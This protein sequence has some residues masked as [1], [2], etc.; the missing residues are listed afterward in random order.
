MFL[1]DIMNESQDQDADIYNEYNGDNEDEYNDDKD[2]APKPKKRKDRPD[3]HYTVVDA[4]YFDVDGDKHEIAGVPEYNTDHYGDYWGHYPYIAA[5]KAFTGLQKHMKKFYRQR[6][7]EPWFPNY[8]P[9]N[10]PVI[11]FII[12]DTGNGKNYA[13]QG[14]RIKAP[15][16]RTAPRVIQNPDGRIRTYN[17]VNDILPLKD[18]IE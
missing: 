7:E 17:W 3:R 9:D 16:S 14:Q 15:Q 10:P 6:V 4:V 5:S 13:Y 12:Q 2:Q 11:I 18:V 8:S 1:N